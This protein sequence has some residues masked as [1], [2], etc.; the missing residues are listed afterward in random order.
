M[1]QIYDKDGNITTT[2]Y[3]DLEAIHYVGTTVPEYSGS[4]TNVF[5]YKDFELS[6]QM[7]YAGGHK[8]RNTNIPKINMGDPYSNGIIDM[9]SKDIRKRWK[10][11]GDEKITDVPCLLFYTSPDFNYDRESIYKG[12]D[13]HV[14]DASHIKISNI[15]LTYK[16]PNEWVKKIGFGG[17][18]VQFNIENLATIAFDRKAGY[19]LGSKDKPNYVC[20][21]YLNF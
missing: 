5:N 19:L 8:I 21:L 9:T 12:A 13:I 1:R 15:S 2:D 4:F 16:I 6:I 7:L 10:Q 11:A 14:W 18:R 20:G 3:T 17:A